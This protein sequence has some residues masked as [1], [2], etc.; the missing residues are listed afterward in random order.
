[1]KKIQYYMRSTLLVVVLCLAST[2]C[3]EYLDKAPEADI[4]EKDV[5]GSFLSFQ[6][7]VE[8][9]YNCIMDP[10]KGGAWNKYLFA[11]ETLG[12]SPYQFD[13]G[14]YWGNETYFYGVNASPT[15]GNPRDRRV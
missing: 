7:F 1:M 9:M 2:S 5:Y 14:N 15:S 10:D 8:Q 11:D 4:T 6:G 13:Y 12:P 3:E